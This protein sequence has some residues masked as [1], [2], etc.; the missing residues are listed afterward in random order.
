MGVPENRFGFNPDKMRDWA[1]KEQEHR[2]DL[3]SGLSELAKSFKKLGGS[4]DF[5]RYALTSALLTEPPE[6]DIDAIN[7]IINERIGP[8][9]ILSAGQD[10]KALIKKLE[11]IPG[12]YRERDEVLQAVAA[13]RSLLKWIESTGFDDLLL[14][15]SAGH[16]SRTGAWRYSFFPAVWGHLNVV[17]KA[18]LSTRWEW[19]QDAFVLGDSIT[20][21]DKDFVRG[22]LRS[23]GLRFVDFMKP[24][25]K[26]AP[27]GDPGDWRTARAWFYGAKEAKDSSLR[28]HFT[29]G[30]D[31]FLVWRHKLYRPGKDAETS[32][33]T[34]TRGDRLYAE[35]AWAILRDD[36]GCDQVPLPPAFLLD[37][38]LRSA[39]Q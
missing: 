24:A 20:G 18:A 10:T 19:M 37:R 9:H 2:T 6:Q 34:F 29:A 31:A 8:D 21:I 15:R 17:S 33:V 38:C 5:L 23:G 13:L 12:V 22:R 32:R 25:F 16:Q 4:P 3:V 39:S 26:V 11:Q 27:L 35:A 28:F 14:R 1:E 7:A 30:T 36:F